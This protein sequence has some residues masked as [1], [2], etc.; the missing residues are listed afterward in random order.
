MKRINRRILSILLIISLISS[1][2]TGCGSH[3]ASMEDRSESTKED[4]RLSSTEDEIGTKIDTEMLV[5]KEGS[6]IL[7]SLSSNWEDYV[8][9]TETFVYGL[10]MNELSYT[11]DVFPAS[12]VLSDGLSVFGIAYTDYEE[13]YTDEKETKAYFMAGFIPGVGELPIPEGEF[14]AGLLIE[15]LEFQ[16]ENTDFILKYQSDAFSE[17]CVVYGKYVTYGVSPEGQMFF[18][19]SKYEH[20]K[21]DESLGSL[22]SFDEARY[23]YDVDLGEYVYISG[24]SLATQLDYVALEKEI[25]KILETQDANF[26]AVEVETSVYFAQEAVTNYLLSLQEETFLGYDVNTLVEAAN[27]LDPMECYRITSDGLMTIDLEYSTEDEVAR[28][29]VGTAGIIAVAAGMVGSI[30]FIECPPL[31]A[32]SSAIAGT[33]I[34]MFMQVVISNQKVPDVKWSKVAIAACSGAISGYLGPY[35]AATTAGA[36]EFIV[37]SMLDGMIGGIEQTVFAWMDGAEGVE[38]IKSFGY[39]FAL[40]F[41]LSAGFKGIGKVFSKVA[42]KALPVISNATKKTMP[43]LS[44]K[45]SRMTHVAGKKLYTFKKAADKTIFHSKY[46]ANKLAFKQVA[47]LTESTATRLK[48]RSFA[49]IKKND[50]ILD[51][52]GRPI[53]IVQLEELFDSAQDGSVIGKFMVDDDVISIKRQNGMVGIV[54]DESKYLTVEIPN[55]LRNVGYTTKKE[56]DL[57]RADNFT[58]AAKELK[59]VWVDKPDTIP[60]SIKIALGDAE[61]EDVLPEKIVSIIRDS[62]NGWVLHENIDMKTITL[63]PRELHDFA[64]GGI[65]HMGGFGLV[66]YVKSYMGKTFFDRFMSAAATQ[67]VIA[68]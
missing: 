28:W 6:E 54:Y 32:V 45:V 47:Q 26:A 59:K 35:I 52:N 15:N 34:E 16:D 53:S 29:L 63:V 58:E 41:G 65:A 19:E 64:K 42:D 12:I 56:K 36:K 11:Y 38:M 62:K 61:L 8:G 25:N 40:G 39:G 55:G 50:G 51:T 21:C 1:L 60:D 14:D 30:V 68:Q 13:C 9:D 43:M 2:F 20:G 18:E 23:V 10:L 67:A 17:H 33:G 7:Y 57:Y 66:G 3:T 48:Q 4:S 46:V 27:T 31:S 22:Y 5:D 37:D 49:Q 24:E 44:K